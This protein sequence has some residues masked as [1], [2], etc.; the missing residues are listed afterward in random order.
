MGHFHYEE[1]VT[2]ASN[3]IASLPD[4]QVLTLRY[5]HVL[6]NPLEP[7]YDSAKFCGL[8]VTKDQVGALVS[9]INDSRAYAYLKSPKLVDFAISKQA[10]LVKRGYN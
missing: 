6:E 10:E 8:D 1:Y 5:E 7:I 4:D 9:G 3:C 2:Q